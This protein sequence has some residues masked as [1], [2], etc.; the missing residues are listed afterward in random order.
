LSDVLSIASQGS[1]N[2]QELLNGSTQAILRPN[3]RLNPLVIDPERPGFVFDIPIG[4]S[5]DEESDITDHYTENNSYL[6]D[7]IVNKPLKITLGGYIGELVYKIPKGG[8]VGGLRQVSAR[9][10]S[11]SAL[12][13]NY[14]PGF[15]HTVEKLL[16]KAQAMA[17]LENQIAQQIQSAAGAISSFYGL[18]ITSQRQAYNTLFG[19]WNNKTIFTVTT[20]WADISPVAITAMRFSQDQDSSEYS[21]I[22]VT[23]KLIRMASTGLIILNA[24]DVD[25]DVT[26]V[27]AAPG[28][29][30]GNAGTNNETAL[31]QFSGGV[32]NVL[33]GFL[34]GTP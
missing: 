25:K 12:G 7:H 16:A 21:T 27:Q 28:T 23:L 24:N 22:S 9:L 34:G 19:L 14:T 17:N 2:L 1:S 6:N 10:G 8:F 11:L 33:A 20:P 15:V 5:I 4:E 3:S 26:G 30:Q 31:Y 32:K 13:G 29:A 18:K